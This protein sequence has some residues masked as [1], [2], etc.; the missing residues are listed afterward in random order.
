MYPSNTIPSNRSPQ[1]FNTK[2]HNF[3][4]LSGYYVTQGS[5]LMNV[6]RRLVWGPRILAFEIWHWQRVFLKIVTSLES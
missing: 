5:T 4:S 1:L 2:I 6:L 3:D